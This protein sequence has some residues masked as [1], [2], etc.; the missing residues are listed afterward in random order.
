MMTDETTPKLR[1]ES[2]GVRLKVTT[3]GGEDLTRYVRG[4]VYDQSDPNKV[5]SIRLELLATRVEL[6]SVPAERKPRPEVESYDCRSERSAPTFLQSIANYC[7][8][9]N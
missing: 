3:P 5:G 7:T 1:I 8:G 6:V 9:G 4:V 2:N